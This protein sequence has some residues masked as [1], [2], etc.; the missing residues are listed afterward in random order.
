MKNK[1]NNNNK[2][3]KD[4]KDFAIA[5]SWTFVSNGRRLPDWDLNSFFLSCS[6]SLSSNFLSVS[7]ISSR[8]NDR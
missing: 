4:E 2:R 5:L 6:H 8:G 7:C 1:K 3:N